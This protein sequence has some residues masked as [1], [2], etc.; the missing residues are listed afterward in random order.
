MDKED[1]RFQ[2][3]EQLYERRKQVVRMHRKGFGVMRIVEL[4]GLSYP[5][6]RGVIDRYDEA[7][8]ET[9]KPV[10][11]GRQGGDGRLLSDEQEKAVRQIICDKRPE[12]L[13]MEFALWNRAAVTQLIERECG[14]KLSVRGVGNYLK[15][16]GFTPQKP[17]K[18]AYEQ[19]PEAVKSWLDNEYPAI[20]QRAK[21]E[22]AEIH[23]GDETAVVNTDVRGRSYAPAGQTPVTYAVGGTRQ[24][25]SMIATVTNQGKA[26]W[27]IIDEAFNSDKLIE[28]LEALIKDAE[29]KV[30]LILDNLRVHHSKPV[31]KWAEEHKEKIE[32]FYLPSYSPELNP[33]ER[34]N[35]DLKHAIYTKVPVRTKAKLK[36]ATAEHM[37]ALEKSPER[38][39]KFFQDSRVKY[40]A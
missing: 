38:V 13:K 26:R 5:T 20:E 9:V 17:I 4:S 3:L 6:V 29:K 22:G 40:A 14:I 31:K 15:R 32:L 24:K 39:K 27:M 28:F 19:R 8:S 10:S 35:A 7:G 16:W 11:R 33:E 25:L 21:A 36:A 18:K 2:T 37:Q 1:A 23:W 34:L 12:Q 30:F